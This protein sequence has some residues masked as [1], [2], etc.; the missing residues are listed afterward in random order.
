MR[1]L[2]TAGVSLPENETRQMAGDTKKDSYILYIM[3][4]PAAWHPQ[5]Y[6]MISSGGHSPAPQTDS[7]EQPQHS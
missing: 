4:S 3:T 7:L 5:F 1:P 2:C 6:Q